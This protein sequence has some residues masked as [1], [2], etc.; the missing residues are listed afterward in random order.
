MRARVQW[1]R[2]V[3][4]TLTLMGVAAVAVAQEPPLELGGGLTANDPCPPYGVEWFL[5]FD[6]NEG[7]HQMTREADF[8]TVLGANS[9]FALAPDYGIGA[10]VGTSWGVYDW[11][12]RLI[13]WNDPVGVSDDAAA[14]QH[15]FFVT[16][17][18]FKETVGDSRWSFGVAYDWLV[19]V[20]FGN[21]GLDATL[22]QWRG[23][24]EYALNSSNELGVTIVRGERGDRFEFEVID[25][26]NPFV[27]TFR[28]ISHTD[29]Y[30]HHAMANGTHLRLWLGFPD[31]ERLI[32]GNG[33]AD[34]S[35]IELLI[36][37][38]IQTPITSCMDLYAGIQWGNPS[39][40]SGNSFGGSAE[41]FSNISIGLAFY[42]GR[43]S[44]HRTVRRNCWMPYMPLANNQNFLVD[45]G[46]LPP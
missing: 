17:G 46:L 2:G 36:G 9:G 1:M 13:D 12:G 29:V 6:N 4:L 31:D 25:E 10:Q 3:G 8:G 44:P 19:T 43:S 32:S 42:P 30:W 35:V 21:H 38:S 23:Q 20:N 28:P 18:I 40:S 5:G 33:D 27:E 37:S 11:K 15:Q 16:T 41:N 45:R 39:V 7:V 34:G 22:G 26:P 24:I 14:A